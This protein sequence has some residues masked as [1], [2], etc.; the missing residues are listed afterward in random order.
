VREM[1]TR[2]RLL[3]F[4]L[5]TFTVLVPVV[6]WLLWSHPPSPITREN[7]AKILPSITLAAVDVLL[8]GPSRDEATGPIL[9]DSPI[10]A[11]HHPGPD[12][13]EELWITNRLL[14][15]VCVD[16]RGVVTHSEAFDVRKQTDG[17]LDRLR[18]LLG[19]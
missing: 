14:I 18:R 17:P 2:R 5:P 8:G 13:R 7:A 12:K 16:R 9:L 3:L 6:V 1:T 15:S 10:V 19:L 11:A 4:S